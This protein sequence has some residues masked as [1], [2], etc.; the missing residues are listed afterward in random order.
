MQVDHL[1]LAQR[2]LLAQRGR[3]GRSDAFLKP[4]CNTRATATILVLLHDVCQGW[5][6]WLQVTMR[7][8]AAV[9][10]RPCIMIQSRRMQQAASACLSTPQNRS[11]WAQ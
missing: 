4:G 8:G 5:G 1:H 9:I 6:P 11:G 3:G 7:M 10:S 2:A